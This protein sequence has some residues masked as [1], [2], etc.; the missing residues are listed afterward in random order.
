MRPAYVPHLQRYG[1]NDGPSSAPPSARRPA[2]AAAARTA[3]TPPMTGNQ[4]RGGITSPRAAA[5]KSASKSGAS[6]G[7][8]DQSGTGVTLVGRRVPVPKKSVQIHLAEE[9]SIRSKLDEMS[10]GM[11]NKAGA[12]AEARRNAGAVQDEVFDQVDKVFG[13]NLENRQIVRA[14]ILKTARAHSRVHMIAHGVESELSAFIQLVPPY[15]V[16][17][18]DEILGNKAKLQDTVDKCDE[19][20]KAARDEQFACQLIFT[21]TLEEFERDFTRTL[22]E[23]SAQISAENTSLKQQMKDLIK[24]HEWDLGMWIDRVEKNEKE[25]A[26]L[27]DEMAENGRERL[28]CEQCFA[29]ELME[30]DNK[31]ISKWEG[32]LLR[33]EGLKKKNKMDKEKA[34]VEAKAMIAAGEDPTVD[35]PA[36]AGPVLTEANTNEKTVLRELKRLKALQA[37]ALA[38]PNPHV[39]RQMLF[40]NSLKPP[41]D[42]TAQDGRFP[43]SMSWRATE[44]KLNIKPK[45]PKPAWKPT[46]VGNTV[47]IGQAGRQSP[48]RST[49]P[50]RLNTTCPDDCTHSGS[51]K[52][53]GPWHPPRKYSTGP[54]YD[55]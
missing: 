16:Q 18:F 31:V 15:L 41:T 4:I 7:P 53:L 34:F 42:L 33:I 47:E 13:N 32:M 27:N 50:P 51:N 48:K 49:S 23:R 20:V 37:E 5:S 38:Q 10:V 36:G 14:M 9:A 26:R 44:E 17:C 46:T 19:R 12:L 43:G 25:I 40:H 1:S 54:L 30:T 8:A 24:E 35:K 6:S 21:R 45:K 22:E 2:T 39:A 29:N 55:R 11:C 28:A 52:Q 3:P